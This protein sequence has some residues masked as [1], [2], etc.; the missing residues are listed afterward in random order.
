MLLFYAKIL[1]LLPFIHTAQNSEQHQQQ[2][3]VQLVP[4]ITFACPSWFAHL[5][6]NLVEKCTLPCF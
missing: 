1:D 2:D 5:A 6:E 3:V 4:E